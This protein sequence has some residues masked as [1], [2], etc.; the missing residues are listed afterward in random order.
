MSEAIITNRLST[1]R[2]ME[3]SNSPNIMRRYFVE[4]QGFFQRLM[5]LI[6]GVLS[7]FVLEGRFCLFF[8]PILLIR[9]SRSEILRVVQWIF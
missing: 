5:G 4:R 7:V 6:S 2:N 8:L 1:K 3:A 9:I